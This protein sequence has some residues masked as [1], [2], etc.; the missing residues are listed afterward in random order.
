MIYFIRFCSI[1]MDTQLKRS[2]FTV[3]ECYSYLIV[4]IR[5]K[6]L[7]IATYFAT[8]LYGIL[9]YDDD[10]DYDYDKILNIPNC[11]L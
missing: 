4:S 10:Y 7:V 2:F 9:D 6:S 8:H 11:T 3:F 5:S 1:H